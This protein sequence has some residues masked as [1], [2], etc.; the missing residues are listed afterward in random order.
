MN[1]V[2]SVS[3]GNYSAMKI[4][5]GLTFRFELD[6]TLPIWAW[7]AQDEAD[8]S[9]RCAIIDTTAVVTCKRRANEHAPL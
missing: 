4:C 1:S 9:A 5:S 6:S 8:N 2:V 7:F 3:K